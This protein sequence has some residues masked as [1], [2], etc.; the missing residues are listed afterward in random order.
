M[1]GNSPNLLALTNSLSSQINFQLPPIKITLDN[2]NHCLWSTTVISALETFDL[3]PH[4]LA[5]NPPPQTRSIAAE[6]GTITQEPNPD[7]LAWKRRDRLVLL[8][9]K[10][11]LSERTLA[12]VARS[13]TSHMA[14]TALE[15]TFQA[16][17][18]ARRMSLKLQLQSLPKG[19]LSIMDYIERK[20]SIADSLAANL[21]PVS[22]EDLI[23]H[24]LSG[25]DSSYGAFAT[26][27]MIHSDDASVDDLVG[28]LLQEEARLAQELTRQSTIAPLAPSSPA[29]IL[30]VHVAGRQSGRSYNTN[31]SGGAYSRGDSR[32][33]SRGDVRATNGGEFRRR[34]PQCQ[35]CGRPGHEAVDCWQRNNQIDFPSRKPNPR[36]TSKQAHYASQATSSSAI[37]PSWYFDTGATDHASPDFQKLTISDD[38]KGNDKLQVGNGNLLSIS[39]IGNSTLHNLRLPNVLIVPK[40]TKS[41]LSVSKF[42]QDN[43]VYIEFWPHHC[44]VKTFQGQTILR[45]GIN[46]GLYC[47]NT[48]QNKTRPTMALTGVRTSVHGWHQRLAHPHEPLLRRLISSFNL[49]VSSN[50]FPNVC[51]SC[52]LGKSHRFPLGSSH[53]ASSTPF[54]LIYSDVWG[55]SPKFSINGNRYF[56]L[57]IDDCTK[58][59]WI[60]FLSH[61]SQVFTTFVQFRTMIETQFNAKI[62]HLQSDW[63]GEFRNVSNF[64]KQHGISH[65]ISCPYTQEQ[66]GAVERRNRIIIE[67]GL[68]LL[69]QSSLPHDFWEHAFKTATYLH[70]RTITPTL[71]YH[72]PYQKLYHK[73]P[74]YGFLKTFGCL[75]YPF[76]RPYN[77]HKIDFRSLPCVFL[78]YST[79]HKGYLCFHKP[80]E[81]IYVA[82][83]VVFNESIF[84][85]FVSSNNS[86]PNLSTPAS[87][88]LNS[89]LLE[90]AVGLP[91]PSATFQTEP[92][93]QPTIQPSPTIPPTSH[94]LPNFSPPPAPPQQQLFPSHYRPAQ[95]STH[96]MT[97]RAQTGSLKPKILATTLKPEPDPRTYKQA[98]KHKHWQDAMTVEYNALVKNGTWSLVPCPTNVNV[99]GCKWIYRTKRKSDG[100][101]ERHKARLVAQGFSQQAG[102]D[103]FE[104]FSPVVKPTTI[105]LVLSIALSN[106]WCLRQLDINNAFLNG[107]LSEVVYMRQPKGFE[108]SHHPDHVCQLRKALYGLKQAPRAWFTKLKHYLV[109]QGFRACQSD[110]SLFVHHSAAA[111]IYILVYVDDLIITGTDSG[112]INNFIINLNKV[113]ALKDQGEL[114]YFLGLQITRTSSGVQLTQEG[115]VRD[116]LESTN[117]SAAAPITTPADP[118]HRLV[119]AGD[120][121]DDPALYRRTVGSLQYATITRPDITYAVNRVCQFMHSPTLDHWRAVKRIL[122]YLA[123]TLSHSLHFSPTQATSFLA[124]SDAGWISDS[125][126]SR[127]Q[128]GYAIFHGSN[129]I[130]WTSRKQKV[131][132][133][134]S[135]EAEYRSL[136]YTAAELLWLNI[137]ASELHVPI[138]GSPLLLCDNVGAI[139][140]SKNPVISTRSKHIALDFH[141]LR[142]QVDSGTLKI[143]HVSSVDQLADI[144][145]KPLSKDRVSFLRSKLRVLPNHQLAGG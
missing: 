114:H 104:T 129:L 17:T 94:S 124:Y 79:S 48:I 10:S 67:K 126:D 23:G 140:L 125:D 88:E 12:I 42:T 110:T 78:G 11:T 47:I 65:R 98:L 29:P 74:N 21:H 105:R 103:F 82:R 93:I 1:A 69:A 8:W 15:K 62:K 32:S 73:D 123:G 46:N 20:R 16:Q 76:L 14:W 81:R 95:S 70:N 141:F 44:L 40:L 13:T 107:E 115:Y 43:K 39:H 60:Y 90:Q 41:L 9:L 117:M 61:K 77:N 100:S 119:R 87:T 22:D 2:E 50:K 34:R 83:H 128:F 38:Y 120:P 53:I 144:F 3:E 35:L 5:P 101:I 66:N 121:F 135:T 72:S 36:S 4:L 86:T 116:I 131:V 56:V 25:L 63:G 142:D 85:Y 106:Q 134:S 118:Q 130:S 97:T 26:A 58:Y 92:A 136:A 109:T 84:P 7:Y 143:G 111:T 37:D 133:R 71:H 75:C 45:G 54:E 80:T 30:S 139:F 18:R 89:N 33:D 68:T 64:L 49:P 145:T 24:I 102:K 137:L 52:Q 138:T 96:P 108:D 31:N 132:A 99:V 55:P 28:K 51:D 27:F 57:F 112:L 113:F 59:V 127:S 122:R 6:D 19:S 91:T